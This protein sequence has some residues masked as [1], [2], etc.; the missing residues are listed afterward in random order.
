MPQGDTPGKPPGKKQVLADDRE[1]KSSEVDLSLVI[2]PST[3]NSMT[4]DNG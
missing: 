1:S 4:V 3:L 2:L